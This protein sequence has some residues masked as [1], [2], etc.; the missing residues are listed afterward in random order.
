MVDRISRK[1]YRFSQDE[2]ANYIVQYIIKH[3]SLQVYRDRIIKG[4]LLG[5]VVSLSQS[6]YSSHVVEHAFEYAPA[7]LFDHM[8]KEAFGSD[9]HPRFDFLV[10][11]IDI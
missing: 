3:R 10:V 9:V 7:N 6:K 4:A 1:A 2:Y 8:I 5:N 11:G